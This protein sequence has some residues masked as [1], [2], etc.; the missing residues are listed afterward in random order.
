MR[1]LVTGSSGFIGYHLAARLLREG[2]QVVGL[3]NLNNYYDVNLK[4]A[5]TG[6]LQ[7]EPN[8]LFKKFN[9]IDEKKLTALFKRNK[10]EIVVHLAAQ[11]GVRHSIQQ[12]RVYIDSNYIGFFNIL[13]NCR[14][15]G[16][17]HLIFASS[18]SVYGLNRKQPFSVSDHTDHPMS[19][20]A[21]SK[22]ANEMMAHSY[23]HLF[24]VACTG[25]RFFTVYG[26]WG[27]PDMALWRFVR[28]IHLRE[29]LQLYNYG[30]MERDFTYVD[31]I[32]EGIIRLIPLA[33]SG[34]SQWDAE[35]PNPATS[36]G[37]YRLFNI[38]AGHPVRLERFLELIEKNLG[39]KAIVER[40]PMQPGDIP[41]T[42]ASIDALKATTGYE[43]K[44]M[45]E[46]G[47]QRY[48]QWFRQYYIESGR[49]I[50]VC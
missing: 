22:K 47:I 28:A 24:G 16:I 41:A 9:L 6:L 44:V 39:K 23:C 36:P 17:E 30:N 12:P 35:S 38:G 14:H 33:P 40:V 37:P 2:H 25:L 34:I 27:R 49:P 48:I 8:F 7:R 45:V 43:P 42:C 11:A 31:D 5:R 46:E 18:S 32:V 3:D 50:P 21:A 19:L 29:P 10:F 20:Y 1:I 15:R 13:E 4:K 26:P